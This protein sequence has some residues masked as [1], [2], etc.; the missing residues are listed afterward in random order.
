MITV[1]AFV[2]ALMEQVAAARTISDQASVQIAGQHFDHEL[3]RGFPVPLWP[4]G[5]WS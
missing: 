3:L 2:G 5:R 4:S 1:K